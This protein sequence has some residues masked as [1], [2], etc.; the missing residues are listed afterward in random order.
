MLQRIFVITELQ[1]NHSL[2]KLT[3]IYMT[4]I[5]PSFF[6][7]KVCREFYFLRRLLSGSALNNLWYFFMFLERKY[8]SMYRYAGVHSL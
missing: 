3:L 4:D 6:R 8:S 2:R 5:Q 7:E 1:A